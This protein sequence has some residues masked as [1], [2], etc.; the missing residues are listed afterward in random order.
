MQAT[1]S[2][3]LQLD[4]K[5][6]DQY[7]AVLDLWPVPSQ[8]LHLDTREGETFVV[9]CGEVNAPPLILLHGALTNSAI[10]MFDAELWSRA[11][12]VYAIDLIG[13][14]GFSSNNHPALNGDAWAN[15]L[16][17]VLDGLGVES[18]SLVGVSFGGWVALDYAIRRPKRVSQLIL[19]SPSGIG[20]QRPFLLSAL[21]LLLLGKWGK[22]RLRAMVMGPPPKVVP[23]KARPLLDLVDT[24]HAQVR[25]RFAKM[26][27]FSDTDLNGV[28]APMLVVVGG[29]DA[30]L[31][32]KETQQRLNRLTPNASVLYLEHAFHH[33]PSQRETILGFLEHDRRS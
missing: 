13:E 18:A 9:A 33:L 8:H 11:F 12:H 7:R 14:P 3:T 10:W 25:P 24:I 27:Q 4:P 32:S 1:P 19:L 17:D 28:K 21:P 29:S 16:D 23:A 26:P 2:S 5:L 6:A 22:E 20:R 30:L 31:N 15:W